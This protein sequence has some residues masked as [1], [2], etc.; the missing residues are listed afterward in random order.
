MYMYMYMLLNLIYGEN[1]LRVRFSRSAMGDSA[2]NEESS[3]IMIIIRQQPRFRSYNSSGMKT[4]FPASEDRIDGTTTSSATALT[5]TISVLPH[6]VV[7]F[8]LQHIF[9]F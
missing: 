8:R 4:D 2:Q 7:F 6:D 5:D 3:S 1:S 9:V